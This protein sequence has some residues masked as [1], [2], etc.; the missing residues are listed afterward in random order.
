L[1]IADLAKA[2]AEEALRESQREL[3]HVTRVMSMAAL[4]ASIAHDQF[5]IP[6]A[7]KP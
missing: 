1:S 6:A 2:E 3:A 7:P 5:V 4:T